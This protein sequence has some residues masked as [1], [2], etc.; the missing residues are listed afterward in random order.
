[1]YTH[2]RPNGRAEAIGDGAAIGAAI[3]SVVPVIGTAIGAAI[4]AAAGALAKGI[5]SL[6]TA[7]KGKNAYQAG[8]T[9]AASPCRRTTSRSG[10]K[11]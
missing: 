6:V 4:G 11:G 7:I 9:W 2:F 8:A 3:G 10:L 1:M 5:Q